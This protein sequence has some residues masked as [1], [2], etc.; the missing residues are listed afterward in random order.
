M[1]PVAHTLVGAAL[2]K[3][4]LETRSRFAFAALVIGANLPD[5]DGVTYLISGDLGLY[6]RRGWTH[7]IP[8]VVLWPFLLA[9]ALV[10]L[11]KIF[12]PPRARFGELLLLGFLAVLTHPALDWLNN[13][14]MR[15]LMPLDDRWFYGDAVF[16]LDPWIWL[17]LGGAV[18]L[19]SRDQLFRKVGWA[20]VAFATSLVVVTGFPGYVP[21]KIA[22][23]AGV[24]GW[25]VLRYHGIPRTE[26]G[27]RRLNR[28][29][30]GIVTLYVVSL[31]AL[32]AYARSES[33]R[34]LEQT[35]LTVERLMVGPRPMTPFV[36]D[37]VAATPDGYRHGTLH[38]WPSFR[39]ELAPGDIPRPDRDPL[40]ARALE[41]A[42]V[43]GFTTWARFPWAEVE[44][45]AEGYRVYL[46]DARYVRER[47]G[48]FGTAVV[49][50]V[51]DSAPSSDRDER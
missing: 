18:F 5:I 44:T 22:F 17:A 23:L 2:A 37:V 30:L 20:V 46:R 19:G 1:D 12:G 32:G 33:R 31:V 8:A 29:A 40:A 36:K 6:F 11:D 50:L 10:L 7:G 28:G 27:V 4:G 15:W 41:A 34:A 14:G 38:L 39:L 42:E 16:I 3:S 24:A 47:T 9:G 49:F 25:T 51:R 26:G 21:G 45:R 13:Y 48:G 35:G 43:R